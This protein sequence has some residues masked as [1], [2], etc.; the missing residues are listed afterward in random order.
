MFDLLNGEHEEVEVTCLLS[1]PSARS[2]AYR[3]HFSVDGSDALVQS[4]WIAQ[5]E[6]IGLSQHLYL[7]RWGFFQVDVD[8]QVL[9]MGAWTEQ[10]APLHRS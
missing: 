1:N 4:G 10:S 9:N 6:D 7:E 2:L 5:G 8:L 3:T